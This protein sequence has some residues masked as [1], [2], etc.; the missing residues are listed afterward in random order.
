MGTVTLTV[1][2]MRCRHGVRVVT[3]RLR[4]LAGVEL[5]QADARSGHLMVSGDV[6]EAQVREV[7]DRCAQAL[8]ALAARRWPDRRGAVAAG[9][10]AAAS[11]VSGIS[12]FLDGQFAKPGL[13]APLVGFQV[14]LVIA[15]LGVAAL[16]GHRALRLFRR[17][18]TTARGAPADGCTSIDDGPR[19]KQ[20]LGPLALVPL[21]GIRR[22][23]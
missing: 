19:A 8:L 14:V 1:P 16:A 4:D 15:T 6:T 11:V 13:A 7:A 2:T 9:L 21:Q 23:E 18:A 3:A 20:R 12:G 5:V 17:F 10:L 22:I